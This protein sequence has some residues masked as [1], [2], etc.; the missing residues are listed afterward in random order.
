MSTLLF[1]ML[2]AGMLTWGV[3]GATRYALAQEGEIEDPPQPPR[4]RP[5]LRQMTAATGEEETQAPRRPS[6]RRP[7]RRPLPTARKG[8]EEE[9]PEEKLPAPPRRPSQRPL[10]SSKQQGPEEKETPSTEPE[11]ELV[12]LDFDNVDI[13]LVIKLISDLTG[14]NFILSDQ[15]R[16]TV[17]VMSPTKIPIDALFKVLESICEVRGL[18]MVPSGELI[19]IIPKREGVKSPID[20]ETEEGVQERSPEDALVTQ[21]L[22]LQYADINEVQRV[23]QT[24]AGRD[25]SVIPFPATNTL[26]ISD[27]VSNLNRL[28]KIIDEVDVPGLESTITVVPLQYA[29][30]SI[31]A[32]EVL[33]IIQ[34]EGPAAPARRPIPRRRGARQ[35]A[36]R[37]AAAAGEAVK[38]FADER[39]N[40]LIIVA[41]PEDTE[42]VLALVEELDR[43]TPEGTT[44][45]RVKR[46]SYSNSDD[47]AS[48]ISSLT[49]GRT[50][51][52]VSPI[53]V[54]S[55]PEINALIIDASPQDYELL[56]R[57]VEDLDIPRDQVMVE[58]IFTEV[59]LSRSLSVNAQVQTLNKLNFSPDADQLGWDNLQNFGNVEFSPSLR[60]LIIADLDNKYPLTAG[61]GINYG[62]IRGSESGEGF[63]DFA[64]L[65]NALE[66]DTDI[67]VLAAPQVLT[68]DNEEVSFMVVDNIPIITS[69]LTTG[70]G[71]AATD[72]IQQIDY[73]DVGV[74]IKLIPHISKDRFVRLEIEQKVDQ[75]VGVSL[76]DITGPLTPAT[77]KRETSTVVS[78]KDHQTI[79]ISGMISDGYTTQESK[80]PILGDIPILGML[81]RFRKNS[82]DKK[83]LI[84][85][86]TPHIVRNPTE[87]AM[88]TQKTRD[89]SEEFL[90]DSHQHP[91]RELDRFIFMPKDEHVK[92][93]PPVGE[94]ENPYGLS[95]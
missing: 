36:R 37:T 82:I 9:K 63:G 88:L 4:T 43:Q 44:R 20:F 56:E 26:I 35:P 18:S 74:Q 69:T 10:P 57:I 59:D 53:S 70:S 87:L 46:L 72:T 77:L 31:L 84:I 13:K 7:V 71:T 65:V 41:S 76:S 90:Q 73:R 62:F 21:L 32:E 3:S 45:V 91:P 17:T 38:I 61:E 6:R 29:A 68:S 14:K 40:A 15:V 78:V 24:L 49:A 93:L 27:T 23:V 85:F 12:S 67:N 19:K 95:K 86:I 39:T 51:E 66:A 58:M 83:N 47:V 34:Q 81:G 60:D 50:G 92:N 80:V 42:R 2:L 89:R 54:T 5:V 1:R 52:G 11:S 22:T 48:V 64:F 28:T 33:S 79:V 94:A 55:Y 16:G 30:A 75:L 8:E 25:A